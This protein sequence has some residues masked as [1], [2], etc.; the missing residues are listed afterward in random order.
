MN[1]LNR[2]TIVA[3]IK[4][5]RL[6]I[7]AGALLAVGGCA[8][9]SNSVALCQIN[10]T[11]NVDQ[12]FAQVSDKLTSNACH[13]YFDDYVQTLLTVAKGSP[14]GDNRERFANLIRSSIDRG[15]ISQ[16]QG[17]EIFGQ[18]FDTEFYTIKVMQRNNCASMQNKPAIY[19]S[20]R[21]ELTMKKQGLLDIANDPQG[22]RRAQNH[23]ENMQH[24]FDAVALACGRE[25]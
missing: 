9:Q 23:Y 7:I 10:P 4:T 16:R 2:Q 15:V 11:N 22:F 19:A 5:W 12:A 13:Y 17:Q 1:K 3:G 24:V 8:S 18:Y 25:V 6:W 14:G 21:R 20:M